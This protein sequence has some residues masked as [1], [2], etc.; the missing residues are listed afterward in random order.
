MGRFVGIALLKMFQNTKYQ[1]VLEEMMFTSLKY[2]KKNVGMIWKR[3]RTVAAC[4]QAY[5]KEGGYFLK[6]LKYKILIPT[7]YLI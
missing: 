5:G 2:D 1:V 6:A 4:G 7:L 3:N